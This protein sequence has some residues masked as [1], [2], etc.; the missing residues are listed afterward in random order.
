M[1]IRDSIQIGLSLFGSFVKISE[2]NLV[3]F[4][5]R[6]GIKME[7][8]GQ[9]IV[10]DEP[11]NIIAKLIRIHLAAQGVGNIPKLLLQLFF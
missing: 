4:Q 8:F 2:I 9:I 11:E 7:P 1:P 6:I 10:E 3:R 5:H